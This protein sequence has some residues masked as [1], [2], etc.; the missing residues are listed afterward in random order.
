MTSNDTRTQRQKESVIKWFHKDCKATLEAATGFGKTRVA[1]I[2]A[3]YLQ[4]EMRSTAAGVIVPS[5]ILKK[6][7]EDKFR[8]HRING[9]VEI[10][11][12][13]INSLQDF[14]DA[15][16]FIIYDEVHRYTGREWKKV[17]D[18]IPNA[19]FT[20][21]LSATLNKRVRPKIEE[22]LPV[23]E[24]IPLAECEKNGWTADF[25]II[26]VPVA[27]TF[28][29]QA[30]YDDASERFGKSFGFFDRD[31]N[32]AM[33]CY[34]NKF[35]REEFAD[36]IDMKPGVVFGLARR[37][38]NAMQERNLIVNNAENKA[39]VAAQV[40]K[41]NSDKL[42]MS[43]AYTIEMA[44]RILDL[45]GRDIGAAYHSEIKG[46]I[47][48]YGKKIGEK[49]RKEQIIDDFGDKYSFL[50]TAKA[51]DEGADIPSLE[52]GIIVAWNSQETQTQQRIGRIVRY[53]EGKKT[54]VYQLFA[55]GTHDATWL[56]KSQRSVPKSKIVHLSSIDDLYA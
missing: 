56:E 16:D 4:D 1:N 31:F 14:K 54:T 46:Y 15:H 23:Y 2:A 52:I 12:S 28:A 22:V 47:D 51:L 53:E 7:W 30:A 43:F 36:R 5:K 44:E 32:L 9:H 39:R 10:V 27:L 19:K 13:V 11:N 50:S 49:K 38:F 29:E 17:L 25:D 3:R 24:K 20:M 40:V 35:K 6:H 45:V 34:T 26:I 41:N 42:S 21:G 37:F 48:E 8:Q 18:L 55:E 33:A